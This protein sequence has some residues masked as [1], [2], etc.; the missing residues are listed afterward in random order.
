[1]SYIH[2][3]DLAAVQEAFGRL[4]AEPD[5][6]VGVTYRYLHRDGHWT[7][8]EATSRNRL[9]DPGIRGI[10]VISRDL[11]TPRVPLARPRESLAPIGLD[12]GFYDPSSRTV[13]TPEGTIGLTAAEAKLLE[14]LAARHGEAIP[15]ETLLRDVWGYA[16]GV[17]SRTVYA[18]V[19]RL[20]RKVERDP[21][22]PRCIRVRAGQGYVYVPPER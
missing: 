13:V 8:M 7:W 14:F 11:G 18:T 22:A 6:T 15:A 4:L 5:Q 20:R 21:Y 1:M 16:P 12:V 9:A 19:D 10:V 2:P 3:D 17:R